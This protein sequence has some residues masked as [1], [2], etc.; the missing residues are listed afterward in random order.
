MAVRALEVD[1]DWKRLP[2]FK[3]TLPP[4]AVRGTKLPPLS[5]NI[6]Y[7]IPAYTC[8]RVGQSIA[9]GSI[10]LRVIFCTV[11]LPASANQAVY[12]CT[13]VFIACR[14]MCNARFRRTAKLA[15]LIV[16]VVNYVCV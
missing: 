15:D 14:C 12:V 16:G 4:F 3:V 11:I 8:R 9:V 1:H 13:D 10:G 7:R 6:V 5:F 2:F